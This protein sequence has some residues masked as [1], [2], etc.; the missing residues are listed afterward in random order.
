MSITIKIVLIVVLVIMSVM[1]WLVIYIDIRQ[2]DELRHCRS[3]LKTCDKTL[4]PFITIIEKQ[5]QLIETHLR[6]I[7]EQ[8]QLIE[9]LQPQPKPKK[10]KGIMA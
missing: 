4:Q 1:C 5:D 2:K 8:R 9:K 3:L 6:L 7:E 10:V